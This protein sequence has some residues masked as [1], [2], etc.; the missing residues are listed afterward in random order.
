LA[1]AAALTLAGAV[2]CADTAG[3]ADAVL[4][5]ADV[6]G[7]ALCA[8]PAN[9]DAT[10]LD[11]AAGVAWAAVPGTGAWVDVWLIAAVDAAA[12][13]P[14]VAVRGGVDPAKP[15]DAL[16]VVPP[17]ACPVLAIGAWVDVWL[18]AAVDAAAL[19]PEVA[20]CG[21]V[22]PARLADAPDVVPPDAYAVL[23]IGAWV[24]VWLIAA[25]DAGAPAPEVAACG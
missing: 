24:D 4:P 14:E 1:A 9:A 5:L 16:D 15:A 19:A 6:G 12:L 21:G 3:P 13:A 11:A 25:V 8:A 17:D 22:D 2:C 20:A 7:A 23:G 18:I 10:W